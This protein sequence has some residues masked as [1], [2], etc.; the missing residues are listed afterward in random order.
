[1]KNTIII[2]FITTLFTCKAQQSTVSLHNSAEA[3]GINGYYYKDFNNYLNVFEDTWVYTNGNTS[4]TTTLQKKAMVH[5]TTSDLSSD[6]YTDVV[7]GEYKFIENGIEKIN[8][9]QN[10][11]NNYSDPYDYNMVMTSVSISSDINT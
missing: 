5:V 3:F 1:M 11:L 8:T 2:V 9:L 10:L 6:Y 7:I 4:L